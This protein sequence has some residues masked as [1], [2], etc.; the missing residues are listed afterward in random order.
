MTG[1]NGT[2]V[3]MVPLAEAGTEHGRVR[4]A[5]AEQLGAVPSERS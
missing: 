5:L 4:A 3:S 1:L 2:S